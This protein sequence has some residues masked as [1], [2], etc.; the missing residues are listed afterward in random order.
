MME[1]DMTWY[2]YRIKLLTAVFFVFATLS[3]QSATQVIYTQPMGNGSGLVA[4]PNLMYLMDNSGSMAW[5]YLPDYIN[6]AGS[7]LPIATGCTVG[8]AN[9]FDFGTP[10]SLVAFPAGLSPKFNFMFYNPDALYIPPIFYD[11]FAGRL[12]YPQ[13]PPTAAYLD[14]YK[15]VPDATAGTVTAA[16]I[17]SK[18]ASGGTV[19]LTTRFTNFK[20]CDGTPGTCMTNDDNSGINATTGLYVNGTKNFATPYIKST[21]YESGPY[22]YKQNGSPSFCSNTA[23]LTASS[24]TGPCTIERDDTVYTQTYWGAVNQPEASV[25]PAKTSIRVNAVTL[26]TAPDANASV[27]YEVQTRGTMSLAS[28]TVSIQT[29]QTVSLQNTIKTNFSI[30]ATAANAFTFNYTTNATQ[31][32]SVT[33]LTSTNSF[34]TIIAV[35]NG[36]TYDLR[37]SPTTSNPLYNVPLGGTGIALTITSLPLSSGSGLAFVSSNFTCPTTGNFLT[38]NYCTITIQRSSAKSSTA[39]FGLSAITEST[40]V[41]TFKGSIFTTGNEVNDAA[42]LAAELFNTTSPS[43]YTLTSS[44]NQ[45]TLKYQYGSPTS[46]TFGSSNWTKTGINT[47]PTTTTPATGATASINLSTTES[48]VTI[49]AQVSTSTLTQTGSDANDASSLVSAVILAGANSSKFSLSRSG[50]TLSA[51]YIG[52]E[53]VI[54]GPTFSSMTGGGSSG[55][56]SAT[57]GTSSTITVSQKPTQFS[58]TVLPLTPFTGTNEQIESALAS[59]I[60]ATPAVNFTYSPTG[61]T[62]TFSYTG[63]NLIPGSGSVT[64]LSTSSGISASGGPG[65]QVTF[66]ANTAANPN[67][68]L[69]ATVTIKSGGT[70]VGGPW[71]AEAYQINTGDSNNNRQAIAAAITSQINGS[72][73]FVAVQTVSCSGTAN[74]CLPIIA[75]TAPSTGANS[76]QN[77]WVASF[78]NLAPGGSY[79]KVTLD[80]SSSFNKFSGYKDSVVGINNPPVTFDKVRIVSG[81]APFVRPK[82][83]TDCTSTNGD[84]TKNCTY[85]EELNNFANWFSYYRNRLAATKSSVSISF[86]PLSDTTPGAGWRVGFMLTGSTNISSPGNNFTAGELTINDFNA[87]Q[88]AKFYRA[89]QQADTSGSTYLR[90]ITSR[91]GW[92]FAGKLKDAAGNKHDPMQY[93]CQLNAS[94]LSTDGYWNGNGGYRLNSKTIP[95]MPDYD[96]TASIYNNN[97]PFFDKQNSTNTLSDTVMYYHDTDLRSPE[98]GNCTGSIGQDVCANNSPADSSGLRTQK[99]VFYG[100]SFGMGGTVRYDKNY[101]TGSAVDFNAINAGTAFWPLPVA[102]KMSAVDD[103]WHATVNGRGQFF[104]A[105]TPADVT[106]SFGTAIKQ[107]GIVV[108]AASAAA[109]S[110][111][112]PVAGDNFAYVASYRTNKWD[113]DIQALSIDLATGALSTSP[114]WSTMDTVDNLMA[115]NN[116]IAPFPTAADVGRTIYTF[117]PSLA[118]YDKKKFLNWTNVNAD[119]TL[120]SYFD[121]AK[122]LSCGGT[123]IPFCSG[124]TSQTLFEYLMGQN[125]PS[126]GK[127]RPREHVLGDVV[128][129]QPVYVKTAPFAYTDSGYAAFKTTISSRQGAV[130]VGSNDGFLH[131]FNASTGQELWAYSPRAVLPNLYKLADTGYTHDS[132]VDGYISVADAQL[133]RNDINSWKTILV[134]GLG[135]GGKKGSLGVDAYVAMDVTDPTSPKILWEYTDASMGKTFGNPIIT[136]VCTA[137]CNSTPVY[138]WAALVSNGYNTSSMGSLIAIDI[139]TGA[140]LFSISTSSGSN[141]GLTKINNWVDAPSVDSL[142]DLVYGGDDDGNLWRFDLK[143]KTST[144]LA[145]FGEPISTVPQLALISGQKVVMVGTGRYLTLADLADTASRGLYAVKDDG[146]GSTIT[147]PQTTLVKNTLTQSSDKQTRTVT[148]PAKTIDWGTAKGWYIPLP[149]SGERVNVD[150]KLQLNVFSVATNVPTSSATDACVFGGYSWLTQIDIKTGTSVLNSTTNP[151][152]IISKK[153]GTSLAVGLTVIKLPNGKLEALVTTSDNQHPTMDALAAPASV[154]P[155]R[156][157]WRDLSTQ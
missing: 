30:P 25:L 146:T 52:P 64:I 19:D 84:G 109:T 83:R 39:S 154:A 157:S 7:C 58:V 24:T 136:K 51:S 4:K 67:S 41:A 80:T 128:Y 91:A 11:S 57:N 10:G 6:D 18:A 74:N 46:Y 118:G 42:R 130:Y 34:W 23:V 78:S 143:N 68:K 12:S 150:P 90:E 97:P 119:P 71:I 123:G 63:A 33:N 114:I 77:S 59:S 5:G 155:K 3:A 60:S 127:F 133:D 79:G 104:N 9:E 47:N 88:K 94:F 138:K 38:A 56:V 53:N 76:S 32:Q 153:I 82:E 40:P 73:G 149:D 132:F 2:R 106:A 92:Y 95:D 22:Y 55:A 139:A 108:G 116:G 148:T 144:K 126:G 69:T 102:E 16:N 140:N 1:H 113:G 31:V 156:V 44:G 125:Q 81:N 152:N 66:T 86:D 45:A 145:A 131:A 151:G 121:P 14:P 147:S 129:S 65:N 100:L 112:E 93:S 21:R 43:N 62:G 8:S 35:P 107:L 75:I 115:Y 99:M 111:L 110:S 50:N 15:G 135:N 101:A 89:F 103:L 28:G 29:G 120:K 98:L 20:W 26:G 70:T 17:A 124:E 37:I 141:S 48:A 122:V 54:S 96:G 36:N 72:G 13:S 49:S 27:K 142:T 134:A 87:A 117:D 137:T 61:S 105:S 85:I